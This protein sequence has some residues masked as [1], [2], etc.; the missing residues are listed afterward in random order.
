MGCIF[1]GQLCGIC[2]DGDG[3]KRN[4]LRMR[5]GQTGSET[6]VGGSWAAPALGEE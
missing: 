1:S 3:N 2:G 4:D 6:D 5:N